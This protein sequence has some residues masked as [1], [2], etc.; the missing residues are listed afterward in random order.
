MSQHLGQMIQIVNNNS[1]NLKIIIQFNWM[2]RINFYINKKNKE[3]LNKIQINNYNKI[4]AAAQKQ[5]A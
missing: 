2:N 1:Y 5:N 4:Y 3:R